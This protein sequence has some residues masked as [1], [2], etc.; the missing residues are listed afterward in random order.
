MMILKFRNEDSCNELLSKIKKMRLFAEDLE[1][2]IERATEESS[3]SDS[4]RQ[5]YDNNYDTEVE[6][7]SRMS[8][9]YYYP[10]R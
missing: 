7:N 10:R 3:Y 2:C 5:N 6:N 8:N 1:E 9:R 4:R